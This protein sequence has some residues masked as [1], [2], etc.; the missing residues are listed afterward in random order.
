MSDAVADLLVR[1]DATTEQLRRELARGEK[2]LAESDA[3]M[4][5]IQKRMQDGWKKSGDWVKKHNRELKLLGAVAA[6]ASV[7]AVKRIAD[8]SDRY[9]N[10]HGQLKLVTDSQAEVNDVWDQ[11]L[12]ISNDTGSSL[13]ATVT[14][15]ARM[16]RSTKELGTNQA[17]LLQMTET[18]NQAFIVSGATAQESAAS[19][20]QLSQAMAKGR[21]DGQELNAV[22]EQAPRL[23]SLIATEM[24]KPVGALK[25][26]GAAGEITSEVMLAAFENG[27]AE[28]QKEFDQMPMTVGRS[29]SRI[30]NLMLDAFG[31]TDLDPLTDALAEFGDLVADPKIID[32][33]TD[34]AGAL[35]KVAGA[36]VKTLSV[37]PGLMEWIGE[38]AA[39][40]SGPAADDFD[41]MGN[42]IAFLTVELEKMSIAGTE[43]TKQGKLWRAELEKLEK[44]YALNLELTANAANAKQEEAEANVEVVESLEKL[45]EITVEATRLKSRFGDG[46]RDVIRELDFEYEQLNRTARE[47][48]IYNKLAEAGTEATTAQV[49]A[50]REKA[51]ALFDEGQRLKDLEDKTKKLA[52]ASEKAAEKTEKAWADARS[53]LSDFF[54]EMARDGK[55]AFD[56]ILDSFTSMLNKMAAELATN[57]FTLALASGA[58]SAGFGGLAQN[59]LGTV[60]GNT[61]T[62]V[63][64]SLFGS[65]TTSS[66]TQQVSS[67]AGDYLASIG[68]PS[69]ASQGLSGVGEGAV[70]AE[71]AG[72]AGVSSVASLGI[73]ALVV[74][75]VRALDD[76]SSGKYG[77]GDL[78]SGNFANVKYGDSDTSHIFLS[79]KNIAA[80]GFAGADP[81]LTALGYGFVDEG[82]E[83]VLKRS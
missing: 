22:L 67:A 71:A 57:Q 48:F 34:I 51:G 30:N 82:P 68:V 10:L 38:H 17:Q 21:L 29:L 35:V 63:F 18:I 15:Y 74:G 39:S 45:E 7:L 25:D 41:R 27:A 32:G 79:G 28:I 24:D 43:N 81:L 36:G 20:I 42:R 14:L 83:R 26:L 64:T 2:A 72:A 40:A 4:S 80:M 33:L 61:V 66:S 5:K 54:F 8:M 70:A 62:N 53:V 76:L 44:V 9:K 65:S 31:R 69:S 11:A 3:K 56:T 49:E 47:Q 23:A 59:L 55:N 37:L 50:I 60:D 78:L 46:V 13:D 16:A 73:A 12:R 75:A 58:D 52:E 77:I 19:I 6:G 1:I